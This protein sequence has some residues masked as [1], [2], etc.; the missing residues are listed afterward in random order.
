MDTAK[1][2]D[3]FISLANSKHLFF[4]ANDSDNNARTQIKGLIGEKIQELNDLGSGL[5]F[6][7]SNEF[8]LNDPDPS[9]EQNVV[10][11]M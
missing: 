10:F 5:R 4:Q 3:N 7:A 1:R 2:V 6:G 8:G 11:Q 9:P